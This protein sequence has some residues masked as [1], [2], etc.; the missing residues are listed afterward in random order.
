METVQ[1]VKMKLVI[2]TNRRTVE[3]E[4]GNLLEMR[5]FMDRFF[6]Q[7]AERRSMTPKTDY[8]GPERRLRS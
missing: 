7:V 8:K 1:D 5:V 6:T 2:Q 3:E 4:F